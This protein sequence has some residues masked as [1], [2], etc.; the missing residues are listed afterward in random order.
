MNDIVHIVASAEVR[1]GSE[2]IDNFVR[3]LVVALAWCLYAPE[4][5]I[6]SSE[7]NAEKLYQNAVKLTLC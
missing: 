3:A 4:L 5:D 7:A 2:E 1:G 6:K